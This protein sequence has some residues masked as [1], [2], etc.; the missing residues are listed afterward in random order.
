MFS[1]SQLPA[2]LK[3]L[4]CGRLQAITPLLPLRCLQRL[5]IQS[6]RSTAAELARLSTLTGLTQISL[7]YTDIDSFNAG[8][9]VGVSE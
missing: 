2:S 8:Y 7:E 9:Y 3:Y 6:S 4:R 1:D 5:D